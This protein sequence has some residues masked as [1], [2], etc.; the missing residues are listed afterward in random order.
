M[1]GGI[2]F[3]K[4]SLANEANMIFQQAS[5]LSRGMLSVFMAK[6]DYSSLISAIKLARAIACKMWE[7]SP[8]KI[9]QIEG[10]GPAIAN[11]LVQAGISSFEELLKCETSKLEMV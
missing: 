8:F 10:I 4:P 9:K 6:N 11:I 7:T 2:S 5:R 1:L 3:D